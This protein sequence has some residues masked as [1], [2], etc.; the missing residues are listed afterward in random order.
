MK[1]LNRSGILILQIRLDITTGDRQQKKT[2]SYPFT[3][4]IKYIKFVRTLS[5]KSSE[6]GTGFFHYPYTPNDRM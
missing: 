6:H 2:E 1:I 3:W 4:E 5:V